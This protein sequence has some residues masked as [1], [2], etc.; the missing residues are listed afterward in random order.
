MFIK[1]QSINQVLIWRAADQND[2]SAANLSMFIWKI[3]E[4]IPVPVCG[5]VVG[6]IRTCCL[7]M[8]VSS[9]VFQ[10]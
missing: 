7:W 2:P 8:Q 3:E 9:T 4:G 1:Y 6:I 10:G 5:T